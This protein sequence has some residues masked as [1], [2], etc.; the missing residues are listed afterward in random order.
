MRRILV[1][2]DDPYICL[3]VRAGLKRYDFK[4]AI[5][6]GAAN[7]DFRPRLPWPARR[8]P[9]FSRNGAA[10]RRDALPA[11]T[12]QARDIAERDRRMSVRCTTASKVC[13]H[14]R[15]RQRAINHGT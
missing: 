2:D 15:R 4:A 13:S 12:I 10:A 3:A 11:Q 5:A 14:R 1:V 7:R 6:N 9:R 8:Q